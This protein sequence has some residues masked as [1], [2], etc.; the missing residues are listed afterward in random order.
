MIVAGI[1]GLLIA[2]KA[3]MRRLGVEVENSGWWQGLGSST[4]NFILG[5]LLEAAGLGFFIN[6]LK[7]RKRL[8]TLLDLRSRVGE[9]AMIVA[10]AVLLFKALIDPS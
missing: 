10:G 9:I 1:L 3:G 5:G 7:A 8:R 4:R 2:L 6:S